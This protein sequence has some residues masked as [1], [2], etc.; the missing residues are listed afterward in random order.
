VATVERLA[1]DGIVVRDLPWPNAVRASVHA[2]NTE[3]DIDR[4]LDGLAPEL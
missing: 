3:G 4:L 2:V 1:A